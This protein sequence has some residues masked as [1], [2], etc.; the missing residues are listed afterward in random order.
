METLIGFILAIIGVAMIYSMIHGSVI[1]F[2]KLKNLT[3]YEKVV[4][5]VAYVSVVLLVLG[6]IAE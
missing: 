5:W 4:C 3:T 1:V 2:K 6:I